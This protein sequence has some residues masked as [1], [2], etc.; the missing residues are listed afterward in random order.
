MFRY[1]ILSRTFLVFYRQTYVV[2]ARSQFSLG[3]HP[4]RR[5]QVR[6]RIETL[7]RDRNL[8]PNLSSRAQS[9]CRDVRIDRG[10]LLAKHTRDQRLDVDD[11]IAQRIDEPARRTARRQRTSRCRRASCRPM[12][13]PSSRAQSQRRGPDRRRVNLGPSRRFCCCFCSSRPSE[14]HL[15]RALSNEPTDG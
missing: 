10:T 7:A 3:P 15:S 1:E 12:S 4:V 13:R 2:R 11:S 5:T 14:T 9:L 8:I 6:Q